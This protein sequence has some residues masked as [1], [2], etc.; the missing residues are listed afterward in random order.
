MRGMS[1]SCKGQKDIVI[2]Q[3]LLKKKLLAVVVYAEVFANPVPV[4][5]YHTDQEQRF[6]FHCI[7]NNDSKGSIPL[8]CIKT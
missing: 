2:I 1:L 3:V 5:F 4:R 7:L 6:K 8:L